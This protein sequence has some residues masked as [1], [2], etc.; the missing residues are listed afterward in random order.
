MKNNKCKDNYSYLIITC[1]AIIVVLICFASLAV[2]ERSDECTPHCENKYWIH[3]IKNLVTQKQMILNQLDM[4]MNSNLWSRWVD[5]DKI[6]DSPQF[7]KMTTIEIINKM[8]ETKCKL[9]EGT[10]SWKIFGLILNGKPLETSHKICPIIIEELLKIP[11]I[12]NAGFSCFEPGAQ[13]DLH[14]GYNNKILRCHIPLIVPS[15]DTAIKVGFKQLNFSDIALSNGYFIFN[16][17]CLHQ[18]WNKTDKKRIILI[19]DLKK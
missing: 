13:T 5:Y 19:I 2:T 9:D 12:I 11:N 3:N 16:D 10:K 14:R 15:G 8:N 6:N 7:T 1:L 18:S 4:A 17:S